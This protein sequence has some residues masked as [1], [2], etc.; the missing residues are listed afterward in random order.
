MQK[1][2]QVSGRQTRARYKAQDLRQMALSCGVSVIILGALAGSPAVAQPA[3]ASP[4]AAPIFGERLADVAPSSVRLFATGAIQRI[5]QSVRP[6]AQ[7]AVKTPLAIEFGT[8]R[9]HLKD[10]ILRGVPFDL[11]V[12][13]ADVNADLI[14]AGKLA[15]KTYV[16]GE[17]PIGVGVRGVPHETL[18]VSTPEG[19]KAALLKAKAMRYQPGG[20][21]EQTAKKIIASLHLE[22]LVD[23]QF[24]SPAGLPVLGADEYE[25]TINPQSELVR[26]RDW[27][28]LGLVPDTLQSPPVI[29]AALSRAPAHRRE[30]LQLIRFLRSPQITEILQASGYRTPKSR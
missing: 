24:A 17:I 3:A 6:Q 8:A 21:G 15:P 18:D 19:L 9:G 22:G 30:A 27:R 12:L 20:L 29:E 16:I 1:R 26:N 11:V 23:V 28:P 5:L 2:R 25:L 14:G 13:T 10:E 7:A 4:P